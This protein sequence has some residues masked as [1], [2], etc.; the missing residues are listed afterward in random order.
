MSTVFSITVNYNT[1]M[2]FTDRDVYYFIYNAMN[3]YYLKSLEYI[4]TYTNVITIIKLVISSIRNFKNRS[5]YN[6][7]NDNCILCY[8]DILIYCFKIFLIND[9]RDS[10]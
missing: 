10:T 5:N 6:N 1:Q 9:E 8:D 4:N 7:Y 3:S 2:V